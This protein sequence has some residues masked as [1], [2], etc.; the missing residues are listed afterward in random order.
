MTDDRQHM[1]GADSR[2]KSTPFVRRRP[3]SVRVIC[4][5]VP[6]VYRFFRPAFQIYFYLFIYFSLRCAS[7]SAV[8]CALSRSHRLAIP[9]RRSFPVPYGLSHPSP[10]PSGSRRQR[11]FRWPVKTACLLSTAYCLLFLPTAYCL[12]PST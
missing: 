9:A 2:P 10:N 7:S 12:L 5:L 3:L 11:Q 1:T 4:P 8:R 6:L